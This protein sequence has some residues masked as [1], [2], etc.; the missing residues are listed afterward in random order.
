[1]AKPFTDIFKIRNCWFITTTNLADSKHTGCPNKQG[2]QV[3]TLNR[4]RCT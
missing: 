1:M 3:T 4:L 2:N